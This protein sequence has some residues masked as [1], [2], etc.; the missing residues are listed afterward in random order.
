M[1]RTLQILLPVLVLALASLA[2]WAMVRGARKPLSV[3]PPALAPLVRVLVAHPAPVRIDVDTQGTVEARTSI[4]LGAQVGGQVV[5]VADA[6]RAGGFFRKGDVLVTID[7]QDYRLA[8][9]QQ[10]AEVARAELRLLQEQAEAQAA[11]RAWQQLEGDK[12]PDALVRREPQVVE[13]RKALEAARANLEKRKLDL[14][15]TEVKAPFAGRVRQS[16]VDVGQQV[17]PGQTLATIYS[18]DQAEIRLP[19]PASD[20]AFVDLPLAH[21]DGNGTGGAEVEVRAEFGGRPWTWQG[22]VD[23][24]EGEIDRRTRQVTVVAR[25]ADPYT[26]PRAPGQPPLAVGMFVTA[27]IRGRTFPDIVKVPRSALGSDGTLW[28]VDQERRLRRRAV[29]VLHF[30]R[31]DAL[32]HGGLAAGDVVCLSE[33][34]TPTEGMLVRVQEPQPLT[35]DRGADK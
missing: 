35:V 26:A 11:V 16:R 27:T 30:D 13:A 17:V 31:G 9:V 28:I 20:A 4:E 24:T 7:P 19:I 22:V 21:F 14:A 8:V 29:E 12:A 1:R 23:R 15:R 5:A 2:V 3:D 10:E 34:D 6:L 18:I 32:I 33:L 25:I